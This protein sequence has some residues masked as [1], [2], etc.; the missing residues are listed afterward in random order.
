M[1]NVLF[2]SYQ[3]PPLA[4]PGV[5]RSL[6]FVKHL[7]S[8]GYNPI[9]VKAQETSVFFDK[10][11]LDYTLL[12]GL[13]KDLVIINTPPYN[14]DKLKRVCMKLRIFRL[15]WAIFYPLFWTTGALWP[16]YVYRKVALATKRYNTQIVYTTSAPYNTWILGYLLKKRKKLKWVADIRDPFTDGYMWPFPTKLHWHC[17]RKFEKWILS[18]A[19]HVIVNTKTVKDL[20]VSRKFIN[21]SNLSYITNGY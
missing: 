2:V 20:Y 21:S 3:F 7:R 8:Y 17:A 10:K 18:K 1:K 14:L 15:L 12:S 5:H 11:Q 6:N 4:G 13:P 19:D 9:V 16:F